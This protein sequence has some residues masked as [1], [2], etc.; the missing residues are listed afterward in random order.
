MAE[1]VRQ[2]LAR[3]TQKSQMLLERYR[4]LSLRH[5]QATDRI[6]EL[7]GE[8]RSRHNEV[9]D[10]RQQL[11]YAKAAA[12]I[13]SSAEDTAGARVMLTEILREIDRCISRLTY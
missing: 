13:S 9:R 8:L 2:Q 5:R 4:S 6:A 3:V 12:A 11:S 10:L 1:N 7:E